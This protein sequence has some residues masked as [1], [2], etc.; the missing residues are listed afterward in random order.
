[1]ICAICLRDF[2]ALRLACLTDIVGAGIGLFDT[3]PRFPIRLELPSGVAVTDVSAGGG[4]GGGI[5]KALALLEAGGVSNG[6]LF[7][8][9][10]LAS[11][12]GSG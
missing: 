9:A 4:F 1:M 6:S 11:S 5:A 2:C 3:L 12:S 7:A 10:L 8:V